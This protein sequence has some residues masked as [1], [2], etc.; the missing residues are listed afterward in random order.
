MPYL[1]VSLTRKIN[2]P[3]QME[4]KEVAVNPSMLQIHPDFSKPQYKFPATFH[5]VA[6][7]QFDIYHLFAYGANKTQVYCGLASIPNYKKSIYMNGL[8]RN[9]REN[10][11]LDYIEESDDEEDF[12]NTRVDKYVDTEKEILI[13]CTFHKRFKKWVPVQLVSQGQMVVHIN[14]L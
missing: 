12:E 6:D 3:V 4:K 10:R 5:V 11:N 7:I 13:E 9:I 14:K 2:N 1:N 8:F